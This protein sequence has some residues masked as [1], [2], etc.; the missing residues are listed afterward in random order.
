M[1][2]DLTGRVALIGG[3]SQGIGRA[4]AHQLAAAGA[5]CILLARTEADLRSVLAMLPRPAGQTHFALAVDLSQPEHAAS[6]VAE[7]LAREQLTVHVLVN[8]AGGPPAGPIT[9]A[10]VGAFR[11]AFETHLVASQLMTEL[12]VEGMKLA[13]YGRVI[14]VI[15]TSV[16]VPLPGLGVSN[17][18][19]A[20][21]AS[22]AKTWANELGRFGITVNNVLPG[23][24]HTARLEQIMQSR[25]QRTGR[26]VA[27]LIA[28][29]ESEIPMGR[30]G[31]PDEVAAAV[32]FLASPAASYITGINLPVDGGRTPSL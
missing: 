11:A 6:L 29:V 20:A 18:T 5:T 12:V 22:W 13:G 24:T 2:Q 31:S 28:E 21:V 15:S 9:Q 32:V 1:N 4:V 19:R 10:T 23:S 30:I 27:E 25:A 16:K 7:L 14:N 26:S 17:V 3:A 8:N